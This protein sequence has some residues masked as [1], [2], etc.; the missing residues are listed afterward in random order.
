MVCIWTEFLS[1]LLQEYKCKSFRAIR[2]YLHP[3]CSS[4]FAGFSDMAHSNFPSAPHQFGV[5]KHRLWT[6]IFSLQARIVSDIQP[7]KRGR[8]L[9]QLQMLF[10]RKE[11]KCSPIFGRANMI[12]T[13]VFYSQVSNFTRSPHLFGFVHSFQAKHLS[14][15]SI[16]AQ[17]ISLLYRN[18]SIFAHLLVCRDKHE[19]VSPYIHRRWLSSQISLFV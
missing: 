12:H 5:S 19:P 9:G 14:T 3:L 15:K 16:K 13:H 17:Y 4:K 7:L 11:L 8:L 18:K 2:Y 6:L 10:V 1:Y